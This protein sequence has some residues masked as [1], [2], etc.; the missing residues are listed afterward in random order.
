MLSLHDNLF[1]FSEDGSVTSRYQSVVFIMTYDFILKSWKNRKRKRDNNWFRKI[2]L[3]AKSISVKLFLLI[4]FLRAGGIH[5][6][7][8][9]TRKIYLTIWPAAEA[10]QFFLINSSCE[11]LGKRYLVESRKTFILKNI[12][13]DIFLLKSFYHCLSTFYFATLIN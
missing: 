9:I 4:F 1:S 11:Q 2:K 12:H 5:L 6:H 8:Q 3:N 7:P 13:L 10:G